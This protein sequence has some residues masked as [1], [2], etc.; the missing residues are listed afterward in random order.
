[1]KRYQRINHRSHSHQR[2]QAGR[3]TPDII[4][5]IEQADC[6]PTENN[7]EVK[8]REE[9]ALVGEEDFWLDARGKGDTLSYR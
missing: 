9:G 3:N 4:A 6:E 5:E 7:G 8:V 2:E 1:M